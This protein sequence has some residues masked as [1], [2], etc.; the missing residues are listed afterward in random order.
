MDQQQR[1]RTDRITIQFDMSDKIFSNLTEAAVDS[2]KRKLEDLGTAWINEAGRVAFERGQTSDALQIP[3]D[4]IEI[5]AQTASFP[6]K[7]AT[8]TI[9]KEKRKNRLVVAIAITASLCAGLLFG[10]KA[11]DTSFESILMEI[12]LFTGSAA[13]L[14]MAVML[15]NE[16]RKDN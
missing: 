5:V 10:I 9:R 14:V 12:A 15:L 4:A 1:T 11:A 8:A 3:A 6:R 16:Q 7:T 2:V 13:I